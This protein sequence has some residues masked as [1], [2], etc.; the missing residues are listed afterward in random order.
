MPTLK[1]AEVDGGVAIRGPGAKGLY[2]LVFGL[3]IK[4][5]TGIEKAIKEAL[6][7]APADVR[8]V[9]AVDVAKDGIV[10]IHKLQPETVDANMR[11]TLGDG[12]VYFAVRDDALVVTAGVE[13]L[14]AIK[15]A[16]T[17]EPKTGRIAL[18]EMA[19]ASLL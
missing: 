16:V 8:Q 5:G 13:A 7:K 14:D 18:L 3:K 19:V 17:A 4:E 1:M 10:N 9:I 6:K 15:E 11:E 2:T 12:P